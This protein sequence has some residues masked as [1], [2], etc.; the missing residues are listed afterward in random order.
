MH[1]GEDNFF[2]SSD[3][4]GQIIYWNVLNGVSL[5]SFSVRL[6]FCLDFALGK[7]F[8]SMLS[9]LAAYDDGGVR[10]FCCKSSNY[11]RLLAHDFPVKKVCILSKSFLN[12]S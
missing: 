8:D 7:I 4:L 6:T 1:T 3:S 11:Q 5:R 9:F 12:K 2:L 10:L